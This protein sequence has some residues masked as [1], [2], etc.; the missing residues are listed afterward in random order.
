MEV[1]KHSV[2]F[3][4]GI[5]LSRVLGFVRDMSVA[6]IFGASHVS[7]AFF[8]AFRL[9]NTFRRIFGEGGFN[10]AFVPMYSKALREGRGKEF[11]G[12]VFSL[13]MLAVVSVAIVGTLSA[14]WVISLIAPG[15]KDS[16]THQLAVYMAKFIF[17]YVVFVSLSAF[18]MGV[19]NAHKSFFVPAVAQAVFNLTFTLTLLLAGQSLGFRSLILGVLLGGVLQVAVNLPFLF[20]KGIKLG[21]HLSFD[22][23]IREFLKRLAPS[24]GSFGIGQL[25]F[26]IDTFLA[27]FLGKGVISYLY[28][29]NRIFLLPLSLI[30]T[31][32]ANV[33]LTLLSRKEEEERSLELSIKVIILLTLPAAAGLVVLSEEVIAFVYQRGSFSY[34]DTLSAAGLLAVYSLSLPFFSLY[35]V[36]SSQFFSKG[37]TLTPMKGSLLSVISEGLFAFLLAFPLGLGMVGLPGGTFLSSLLGLSYLLLN[38]KETSLRPLPFLP[39]LW[40]ALLS[41]GG[42]VVALM[43]LK[44]SLDAGIYLKTPFLIFTGAFIYFLSCALLKEELTLRLL[45]GLVKKLG[46]P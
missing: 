11:L 24:V 1:L 19:L 17:S 8:I 3:F 10:P 39:T 13:Y 4:F 14:D 21:L 35:K 45:K 44:D 30:S 32:V 34:R 31:S 36:L 42:M 41:C 15:V 23:E 43:L 40:K 26:F 28:Y 2:R 5:L 6:Y 12:K 16:T 7:D 38:L 29:A 20:K 22:R 37:D 9:P 33:L 27:S 18:L 46:Y 25:S